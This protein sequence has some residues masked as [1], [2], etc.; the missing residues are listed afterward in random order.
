VVDQIASGV[1]ILRGQDMPPFSYMEDSQKF[2]DVRLARWGFENG[3]I[4]VILCRDE[5]WL[6]PV[7]Y[8]ET[9]YQGF[10]RTNPPAVAGE[11]RTYAFKVRRRGEIL[12]G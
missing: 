4:P 2:V 7:R 10:T 6:R 9:I 11:I 5:N 1:A 3:L 8:D 12:S